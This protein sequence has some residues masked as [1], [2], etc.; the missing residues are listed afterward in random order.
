MTTFINPIEILELEKMDIATIDASVIKKAKRQLFADIDLSDDGHLAYKGASL[1]KQDCE[2]AIDRLDAPEQVG[3]YHY[4]A[5]NASL[6]D[7]LACGDETW[8][9]AYRQDDIFAEPGFVRM[10]SPFLA[11]QLERSLLRA[12][13]ENAGDRMAAL[14]RAMVLVHPSDVDIAYRGLSRELQQRIDDTERLKEKIKD[15]DKE[16]PEADTLP[17]ATL[18]PER[19][20][21]S[22]LNALPAYFQSQVHKAAA[23]LNF[24]QLA[25]WERYG[26]PQVPVVV[27]EH[28]LQ[29]KI[30]SADRPT[31]ESNYEIIKKRHTQW[32]MEQEHATAL[33][34]WMDILKTVRKWAKTVEAKIDD[35]KEVLAQLPT[36]VSIAEL[37]ALPAYGD[38][39]RTQIASGIRAV[40]IAAWNQ[41]EDI[42]SALALM[43]VASE[44]IVP[45]EVKDGFQQDIADLERLSEKY[46]GVVTCHF[47]ETHPPEEASS[48]KKTIYKET[49][50]T[51]FPQ[52]KVEY[53]YVEITL[54]RC[55]SCKDTHDKGKEYMIYITVV[56][57]I[58][59]I[60]IGLVTEGEHYV[61]GGVIGLG[62]GLLAGYILQRSQLNKT[63]I[64]G[65]SNSVLR[66]HPLLREY[67]NDGWG[68]NKP[69]A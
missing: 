4:L 42:R 60:L 21:L 53:K 20:P 11:P 18:V 41:K 50:R 19:F 46:R 55:K 8:F 7:F 49:S 1:S 43:Q 5:G 62:A 3:Y 67:M 36:L 64:K 61:I 54:P 66:A 38:G 34:P 37:N 52:R 51:W 63:R 68:F 33:A 15:E 10:I 24:L 56:A 22:P 58:V 12:F 26:S 65:T 40:A 45:K 17:I 28:I 32:V 16:F 2:A 57:T 25:I 44:V 27:L 14:L 47:C 31:F 9:A 39:V 59:G 48:L 35:P 6:N 13:V 23:T 29:L 69:A 30:E